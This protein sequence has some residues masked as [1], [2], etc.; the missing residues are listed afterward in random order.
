MPESAAAA[1]GARQ[2]RARTTRSTT[3]IAWVKGV[4]FVISLFPLARLIIGGMLGK[5]GVNPV[6]L[7]TRSTGTWT[8]VFLLVTL[9]VTPLRLVSGWQWLAQLRRMLGLYAFFY[10]FIHLITFVWL[11]HFFDLAAIA[12]DI[13][14]RPFVTMGFAAFAVMIP[15]A[16][17]STRAMTRRLG[18]RRWTAL[19][20]L[21]Y[22]TA[23][24]GVL[25][26]WWLVKRDITQPLIYALVLTLL[27][28]YRL[29]RT[30]RRNKG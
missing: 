14:K 10:G 28:A 20:R 27:L 11:D 21:T 23:I 26:Y 16:V 22:V 9:S 1:G 13:V 18:G 30:V 19:H 8:L 29:I 7:I 12:K 25:H 15:L 5:L 4:L 3:V 17:T 24:C 6:E 2:A